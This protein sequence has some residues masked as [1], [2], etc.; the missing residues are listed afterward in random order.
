MVGCPL[1]SSSKKF[2]QLSHK[3]SETFATLKYP[4]QTQLH[5]FAIRHI[6][7]S[8][9]IQTM[10]NIYN[11]LKIFTKNFIVDVSQSSECKSSILG[12][13]NSQNHFCWEHF[14]LTLQVMSTTLVQ[15][16]CHRQFFENFPNFLELQLLSKTLGNFFRFYKKL[17][18]YPPSLIQFLIKIMF[19]LTK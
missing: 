11:K 19:T 10:S 18:L 1:S 6:N 3:F 7:Q 14:V 17:K 9:G 4:G 15:E 16:L 13:S 2:Y 12:K 8:R 5:F